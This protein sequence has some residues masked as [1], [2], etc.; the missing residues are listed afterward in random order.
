MDLVRYDA[1][2]RALA[3]ACAIDEVKDIAD[4]SYALRQY[5]RQ[6]EN[7]E[8]EIQALE[9]RLRAERRLGQ[10]LKE[11]KDTTGLAPAGRPSK[12]PKKEVAN[13]IPT[14]KE[15]GISHNL[16]SRAQKVAA[17]P[18]AEFETIVGEWRDRVTRENDRVSMK[19]FT[20]ADKADRRAQRET[21]LTKR[22]LEM[23]DQQFGVIYA[24]PPWAFEVRSD[25]GLDRDA[26]NHYPC[27]STQ[28]ICDID[29]PSISGPD[30][31][32][33]MW[34]TCPMLPDAMAVMAAWGFSYKSHYVWV[35]DKIG[36]GYWNRNQHELLLIGTRGNVPAP[37]PGT[38]FPSIID[39]PVAEHS[40]KPAIF[41]EMIEGYFPTLPKI[42]LF[43]RGAARPGWWSYGYEA[44]EGEG[45]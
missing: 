24:D 26:R 4:K 31:V 7:R 30:S 36:L 17:I 19:L 8:L 3:E 5:A 40:V 6:A 15:V 20:A 14:L 13:S 21:E 27:S 12:K 29:V 25:K 33:F 39:A 22:I 16:S 28:E 23:P 45:Q 18:E 34:A 44:E 42:E 37:A 35:K 9:I 2:C 11:Q 32:L 38:Q 43:C 10:M 1:A 41:A